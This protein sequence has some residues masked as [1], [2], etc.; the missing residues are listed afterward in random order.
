MSSKDGKLPS[1]PSGTTE[2]EAF[3]KKLAATTVNKAAGKR[4]RLIF[5]MDATASRQPSWDHASRIQGEMFSATAT[6]GGLEIQLVYYRGFGEFR[7]SP[8][9]TDS[10]ALLRMMTSTFCLAGETQIAKVLKHAVSETRTN[11]VNAL[12]F[13]GDSIEEDVDKLGAIAGERQDVGAHQGVVDHHVGGPERV[14]AQQREQPGLARPGAHQPDPAR[15]EF[16][17]LERKLRHEQLFT[18]RLAP[19]QTAACGLLVK[20]WTRSLS[21]P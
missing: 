4:G 12:V 1:R 16:R 7:A 10:N 19:R 18:R 17:Q 5:A 14:V 8:W 11:R 20:P 21:A 3:L 15:R 13:V 2:V 9:L 6:L